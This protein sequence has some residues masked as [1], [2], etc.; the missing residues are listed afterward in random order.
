VAPVGIRARQLAGAAIGL[1]AVTIWGALLG[2]VTTPYLIHRLGASQYGVFA[3]ITIISSYLLNLEFGFGHATIR[4]LARARAAGDAAEEAAVIGSSLAVF[5]PAALVGGLAVFLGADAIVTHF[6]HG[7]R[8]LRPTFVDAIRL[9]API[10]MFSFL[11]SFATSSLQALGAFDVVVRTRAIFGTLASVGAVAAAAAGGGLTGVLAVQVV[12]S[13]SLALVLF[14]AL[15]HRTAVPLRPSIHVRTFRAMARF[16]G[17]ILLAGL[18]TQIM[19]QGPPTVLAGYAT[20]AQVAAFAVPNLVLQQLIGIVGAT[21]L[22]FL[23][24]ASAASADANVTHVADVYKANLRLTLLV[25]APVATFLAVFAHTLLTTWIGPVF[26]LRSDGALRWLT[27]AVIVLGLSAA[28]S[29]VARGF[30]RP[31]LVTI[32]TGLAATATVGLSFLAV[33][34][35]GAA[36]AAFAMTTGLAIVVIPFMFVVASL[37]LA[38]RPLALL[39]SLTG[40]ILALI[41]IAALFQAG[42]EASESFLWA[43]GV[44]AVGTLLYIVATMTFVLDDR[45]RAVFRSLAHQIRS[46]LSRGPA[47]ADPEGAA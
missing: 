44:G 31:G 43:V 40:P 47:R 30:G 32:Y 41:A 3:L 17:L 21:S 39:R 15:A 42:A 38:V 10:I 5:L 29:D 35:H 4:F 26:A 25:L 37:L 46:K 2:L 16:G 6:A 45:E 13:G 9:G 7:P 14:L 11:S 27:G 28:P 1:G 18:G 19:I 23:P 36:G 24:F 8:V 12:V 20:T 34:D 33:P 22:G